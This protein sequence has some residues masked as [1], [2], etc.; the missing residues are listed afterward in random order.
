MVKEASADPT[1]RPDG[2]AD[3]TQRLREAI[4]AGRFFPNE[5]L[6]E[7][8]L[9]RRFGGTRASVRLALAVLEQQGLVVRERHRGARV[10]LVTEPEAIEII[11]IRAMLESL[12][13]RHAAERAT[14]D[15]IARLRGHLATMEALAR[16]GDLVGY[17][18]ANTEFHTAIARLGRH[19]AA[20]RLLI[21]LNAQTV[22]F[23]FRP[24]GEPGRVAEVDVEH[25]VLVEAIASG[26]PDAAERAMRTHVDKVGQALRA[27]IAARRV[28]THQTA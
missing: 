21:G 10:R 16:A 6:V 3:P 7:E 28:V 12:V 9:V 19:D 27:A 23:Q 14:P 11:E 13:A 4:I 1:Q 24:L 18:Q 2:G 22:V 8:D 15:D 25:R 5:H 17:S 20:E 26:D